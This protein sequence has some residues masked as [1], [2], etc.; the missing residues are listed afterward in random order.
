MKKSNTGGMYPSGVLHHFRECELLESV[1][2]FAVWHK[3]IL[4]LLFD[5]MPSLSICVC[6]MRQRPIST[7]KEQINFDLQ[8]IL[9]GYH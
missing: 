6:V 8:R 3:K 9:F 2:N 7:T 4:C 5:F 1:S